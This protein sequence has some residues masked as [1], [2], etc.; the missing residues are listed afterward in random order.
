VSLAI[1]PVVAALVADP[2]VSRQD[3][4]VFLALCDALDVVEFRVVKVFALAAE[5]ELD[6]SVVARALRRLVAGG[7]LIRGEREGSR[8]AWAYRIPHTRASIACVTVVAE[9]PDQP[10]SAFKEPRSRRRMINFG[11]S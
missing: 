7:Y 11:L 2:K 4:R 10:K 5:V 8:G 3:A 6:D 1:P 9:H